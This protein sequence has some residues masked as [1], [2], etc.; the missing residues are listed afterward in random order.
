MRK[1]FVLGLLLSVFL[2]SFAMVG[3][4]GATSLGDVV[5]AGS[6]TIGDKVFSGW[7]ADPNWNYY[8]APFSADNIT[9]IA[10]PTPANDRDSSCRACRFPF[11]PLACRI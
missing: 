9:F 6:I 8:A 4:A 1:K 5:A 3:S 10:L 2:A 7:T 11:R